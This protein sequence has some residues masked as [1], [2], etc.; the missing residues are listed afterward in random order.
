[1]PAYGCICLLFVS[2]TRIDK[3]RKREGKEEDSV[4][5]FRLRPL[6]G[7]GSSPDEQKVETILTMQHTNALWT[8]MIV[9][10]K[11]QGH[12][13]K[14][15]KLTKDTDDNAARYT[16]DGNRSHEKYGGDVV[17]KS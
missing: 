6:D 14:K 9:V 11:E 15:K 4:L 1:M 8:D 16:P 17:Q 2:V 12:D 5:N 3:E 7:T 10:F 13:L